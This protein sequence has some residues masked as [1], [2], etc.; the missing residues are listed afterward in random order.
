MTDEATQITE[1]PEGSRGE[2]QL[3]NVFFR[4]TKWTIRPG[5]AIPM[6]R[7]DYE[8]VVVPLVTATMHVINSDGTEIEAEL[9]AGVSYTRSAGQ[10]HRCENRVST[11]PIEFVE[12]ERLD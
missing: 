4:V 6:H 10:E 8:Y 1:Y 7:H 11:E 5:G 12:V 2:V 3:D 9:A